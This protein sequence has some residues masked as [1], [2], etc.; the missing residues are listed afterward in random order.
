MDTAEEKRVELHMHTNMSAMDAITPASEL[1][2]T[3][4]RW[5]HK[6]VAITDHGVVQSFPE[7]M[8]TV[9]SIR[10]EDPDFKV[11]YGVEGYFVDDCI[12]AVYGGQNQPFDGNLWYL[13]PKLPV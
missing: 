13:I 11:I 12:S 3:A 4:H 9:D 10:K 6:A 1:I 7:A 8:S 2:K 5:G